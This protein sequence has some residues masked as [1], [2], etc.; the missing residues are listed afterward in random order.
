LKASFD[1]HILT[2]PSGS[3]E[4]SA[5]DA[6]HRSGLLAWGHA[7]GRMLPPAPDKFVD[8]FV[9]GFGR[10]CTMLLPVHRAVLRAI[11]PGGTPIIN[12]RVGRPGQ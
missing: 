7:T 8:P 1:E 3:T 12:N 10:Y 6:T 2:F 11:S 9:Q 5:Q 4:S